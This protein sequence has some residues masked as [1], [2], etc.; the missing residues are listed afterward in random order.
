M[1]SAQLKVTL[2]LDFTTPNNFSFSLKILAEIL[3]KKKILNTPT[4]N[5]KSNGEFKKK[6]NSEN[7][8]NNKLQYCMFTNF[9]NYLIINFNKT[10]HLQLRFFL[11][12]SHT[13]TPT[14]HCS[15]VAY[16]CF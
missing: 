11:A 16:E 7:K 5:N 1:H 2:S 6:F 3:P 14:K 8:I 15:T 4:L 13:I 9:Q 10:C 12:D